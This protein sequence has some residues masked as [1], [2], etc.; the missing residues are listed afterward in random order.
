MPKR[1]GETAEKLKEILA[2]KLDYMHTRRL[3]HSIFLYVIYSTR[4]RS[5]I[6]INVYPSSPRCLSLHR[7]FLPVTSLHSTSVSLLRLGTFRS[8]LTSRCPPLFSLFLSFLL[9]L[10]FMSLTLILLTTSRCT[11]DLHEIPLR[12]SI[13]SAPSTLC[14]TLL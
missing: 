1:K 5:Y 7:F 12:V 10:L 6:C 8:Q 13:H 14:S 2:E 9:P 11:M 4:E 3:W